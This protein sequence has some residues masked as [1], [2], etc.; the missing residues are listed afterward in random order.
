MSKAFGSGKGK[1]KHYSEKCLF[2]LYIPVLLILLNRSPD[3]VD[4]IL[5]L[6]TA[7]TFRIPTRILLQES[8]KELG[9]MF[10]MEFGQ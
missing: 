7:N 9:S 1:R 2:Y 3:K 6:D 10:P 5:H 8:D 4:E